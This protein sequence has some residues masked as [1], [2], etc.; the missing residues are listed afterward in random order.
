[1]MDLYELKD[2]LSAELKKG[3]TIENLADYV[4]SDFVMT[5]SIITKHFGEFKSIRRNT[6]KRLIKEF[7]SE[8]V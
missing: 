7:I 4:L 8:L 1:M 6:Q 3:Q 5:N 2:K